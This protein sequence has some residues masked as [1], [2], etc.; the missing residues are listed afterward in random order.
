VA[1]FITPKRVIEREKSPRGLHL[2][3]FRMIGNARYAGRARRCF[4]PSDRCKDKK[5]ITYAK[6]NRNILLVE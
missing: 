5:S 3:I 1:I 4:G 2:R 6:V